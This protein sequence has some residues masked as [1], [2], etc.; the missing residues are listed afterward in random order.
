MLYIFTKSLQ[1]GI[2][3]REKEIG[4]QREKVLFLGSHSQHQVGSG[5]ELRSSILKASVLPSAPRCP[6]QMAQTNFWSSYSQHTR[7]FSKVWAGPEKLPRTSSGPCPS[8]GTQGPYACA[9][10]PWRQ[11]PRPGGVKDGEA[12]LAW[13]VKTSLFMAVRRSL[14]VYSSEAREGVGTGCPEASK[15]RQAG[16]V[17]LVGS[18]VMSVTLGS[19]E[20]SCAECRTHAPASDPLP[21]NGWI[22]NGDNIE[23]LAIPLQGERRFQRVWDRTHGPLADSSSRVKCTYGASRSK[24]DNILMRSLEP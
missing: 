13:L 17:V 1:G 21:F 15:G 18:W 9:A 24:T 11:M 3:F 16:A 19:P 20:K 22:R 10:E 14:Q 5:S 23:N 6:T 8:Q 7:C 4:V 2:Y 12:D